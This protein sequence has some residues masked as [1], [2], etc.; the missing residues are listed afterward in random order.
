MIDWMIGF[1][2]FRLGGFAIPWNFRVSKHFRNGFVTLD[3]S[4]FKHLWEDVGSTTLPY[5]GHPLAELNGKRRGTLLQEWACKML[6]DANPQALFQA[7]T[8][9]TCVNGQ[10]RSASQAEYDFLLDHKKSE[11]KSSQLLWNSRKWRFLF[12]GVKFPHMMSWNTSS[13]EDLY[14]VLFSPKWLHLVKHD[15]QTG[16]SRAGLQTESVGY[17][18]NISGSANSLCWEES[19]QTILDKLC[20]QGGCSLIAMTD[21]LETCILDMCNKHEGFAR[22]FYHRKP[23]N[24]M[25]PQLR[26]VRV[27]RIVW[28]IDKLLHSRSFFEHC[29]N[30]QTCSGSRRGQHNASVDWIRDGKRVEVKSTQLSFNKWQQTWL[31]EFSAIKHNYTSMSCCWP[32]IVLEGLMCSSTTV[33]LAWPPMALPLTLAASAYMS[34]LPA[35]NWTRYVPCSSLKQSWKQTIVLALPGFF[36]MIDPQIWWQW[37]DKVI[38]SC[39]TTTPLKLMCLQH[40]GKRVEWEAHVGL[41]LRNTEF[42]LLLYQSEMAIG[43]TM[44]GLQKFVCNQWAMNIDYQGLFM[45]LDFDWL[46]SKS[47]DFFQRS[48]HKMFFIARQTVLIVRIDYTFKDTQN[49]APTLSP[50]IKYIVVTV[51]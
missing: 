48:A 4:Q 11:V 5:S 25:S 37:S 9:G 32:Y 49:S 15:L 7:A 23:F 3:A 18:I 21:I 33:F 27:Q 30:E 24:L 20:T 42:S 35:A 46:K 45:Q 1:T 8:P 50:A 47:H 29:S 26:G 43:E 16:I 40:D 28:E 2:R 6:Q 44:P 12:H 10:R 41:S 51:Y 13:F 39:R 22:Q 14:L 38:W 34:G 17:Q 31:C 19:L 36:G